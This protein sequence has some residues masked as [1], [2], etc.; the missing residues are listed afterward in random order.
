VGITT[1]RS[2]ADQRAPF[3]LE[4]ACED[5]VLRGQSFERARDVPQYSCLNFRNLNAG[6]EGFVFV[7]KGTALIGTKRC[8]LSGRGM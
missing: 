5:V 1:R 8:L 7:G 3:I 2:A 6:G 4:H